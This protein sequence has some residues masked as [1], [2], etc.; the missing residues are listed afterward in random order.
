V[1]VLD[2]RTLSPDQVLGLIDQ[3]DALE[4][5]GQQVAPLSSLK[6]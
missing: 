4:A 1:Y 3:I 5:G 6:G 2:V